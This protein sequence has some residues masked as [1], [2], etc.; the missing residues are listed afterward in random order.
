MLLD[1]DRLHNKALYSTPLTVDR[2]TQELPNGAPEDI[3]ATVLA[4]GD[5][6]ICIFAQNAKTVKITCATSGKRVRDIALQGDGQGQ[7][8]GVLTYDRFF[9]GPA[10][11]LAFYDD[12]LVLDPYLP[13][14]WTN[15]RPHNYLEIPDEGNDA[16]L[17]RDVPHG[18]VTHQLFWAK[19]MGNWERCLVYTPP[20]YMKNSAEYPVLYLLNGGTD[21]ETSWEYAGRL[22]AIMDNLIAAGEAEPM[23]VVM[24][25]SMLRAEGKVSMVRDGAFDTM[26]LEDCI[27]FIEANYRVKTQKWDRAIA[28]LSM[29]AYMTCDIAL[30]HSDSFGYVGTFTAC[31]THNEEHIQLAPGVVRPYREF[32][33]Q[34]SPD[35]FSKLFKVYFRSTTEQEDHFEFFEADDR[36]MAQAGYDQ[37]PCCHRTVYSENT[38][39]WNSWRMGLRDYAKLLFKK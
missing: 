16:F 12:Q 2:Y 25:N 21:N 6:A 23:I 29:G 11:V 32:L 24:P 34:V 39:K 7:F 30:G 8:R 19:P 13:I 35:A 20:Q 26:L 17:I 1:G 10:N 27:P 28:G 31:M 36:L 33:K 18:A 4:N 3:G 9:T 14:F 38:S 5:I 22:S 15:N 37:L